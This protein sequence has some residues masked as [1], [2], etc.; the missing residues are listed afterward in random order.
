MCILLLQ[1]MTHFSQEES[2]TEP[3]CALIALASCAAL[4]GAEKSR[5]QWGQG[6]GVGTGGVEAEGRAAGNREQE[7]CL[8]QNEERANW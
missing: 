7:E 6:Q 3:W 4:P 5:G 1:S 2:E 8:K